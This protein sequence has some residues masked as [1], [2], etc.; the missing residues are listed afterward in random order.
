MAAWLLNHGAD[1]NVRAM[2]GDTPLDVVGQWR[3]DSSDDRVHR[4]TSVGELLI[5]RGAEPTARGPSRLT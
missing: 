3:G 4:A 1:A 5:A 2:N